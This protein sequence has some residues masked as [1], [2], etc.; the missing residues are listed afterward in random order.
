M[1]GNIRPLMIGIVVLGLSIAKDALAFCVYNATES[2]LMIN[3]MYRAKGMTKDISAMTKEGQAITGLG[4]KGV[5]VNPNAKTKPTSACCH[6]SNQECS[7]GF[8]SA[9]VHLMLRVVEKQGVNFGIGR[10]GGEGHF[11]GQV[12]DKDN[13]AVS[14]TA[15][16]WVQVEP[17]PSFKSNKNPAA[18]NPKYIVKVFSTGGQHMKT[19]PCPGA[20]RK[21]TWG[22][23]IPDWSDVI[24]G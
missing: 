7:G 24:A 5:P 1:K 22:D 15:G 11:C 18:N 2:R 8:E 13:I 19:Y 3:Q 6:W 17:N 23:L 21:A 9:A 10:T 12:D 14:L 20:E 16:G 4:V